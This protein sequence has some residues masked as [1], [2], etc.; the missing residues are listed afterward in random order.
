M[1]IKNKKIPII[2]G[3]LGVVAVSSIGFATWMVGHEQKEKT[4]NNIAVTVDGIQDNGLILECIPLST[5]NSIKLAETEVIGE[6]SVTTDTIQDT[7][8]GDLDIKLSSFKLYVSDTYT[9]LN[10]LG[11]ITFEVKLGTEA[12]PEYTSN[13]YENGPQDIFGRTAGKLSYLTFPTTITKDEYTK[14]LDSTANITGWN[15]YDLSKDAR[16]NV[17]NQAAL[18]F[19]YGTL[20]GGKTSPATFYNEKIQ[21]NQN[22]PLTG[23]KKVME[24]RSEAAKEL[25]EMKTAF[26]GNKTISIKTSIATK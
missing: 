3:C 5:E 11:D 6:G 17:G 8:K 20:F 24:Q 4:L 23:Q 1:K 7:N 16:F 14:C 15:V 19:S 22:Q 13:A 26:D 21:Y 10:T 18:K 9:N 25:T 12:L 2:L